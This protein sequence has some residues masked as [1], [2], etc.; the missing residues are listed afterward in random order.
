MFMGFNFP[1]A[2]VFTDLG[3]TVR[4]EGNGLPLDTSSIDLPK[5]SYQLVHKPVGP[6]DCLWLKPLN[7]AED[8]GYI[9][10]ANVITPATANIGELLE[11]LGGFFSRATSG[12]VF[13]GTYDVVIAR[14]AAGTLPDGLVRITD[15]EGGV[16]LPSMGSNLGTSG[17]GLFY[18]IDWDT[19]SEW[20][21]ENVYGSIVYTS[22][23]GGPL[24]PGTHI[25]GSNG[26]EG[27]VVFDYGTHVTAYQTVSGFAFPA[28]TETINDGAAYSATV[29]GST[30]PAVGATRWFLAPTGYYLYEITDPEELDGT[31]PVTNFTAWAVVAPSNRAGFLKSVCA[32]EFDKYRSID[33]I[34]F[35]FVSRRNNGVVD[36]TYTFEIGAIYGGLVSALP[37]IQWGYSAQNISQS[38]MCADSAG[39]H[40]G[41]TNVSS[42]QLLA[43]FDTSV[44]VIPALLNTG[45]M[46]EVVFD[47]AYIP[48]ST[49]YTANVIGYISDNGVLFADADFNSLFAGGLD[50]RSLT[51]SKDLA[52]DQFTL[53]PFLPATYVPCGGIYLAASANLEDGDGIAVIK[54]KHTLS[55]IA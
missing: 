38:P 7:G 4:V 45:Y 51:M 18:D 14:E 26:W 54:W 17:T 11:V 43:L 36:A 41:V 1:T 15:R 44:L 33:G 55:R 9:L 42:A 21:M 22:A 30:A 8:I 29:T 10:Y 23:V 50:L 31:D 20:V 32:I 49:P 5:E 24:A 19:V 48:G 25:F 37:L 12:L 27:V 3:D 46:P 2:L 28:N 39:W 53:N 13:S 52:R 16:I 35:G 6:S 40:H 34:L 47:I